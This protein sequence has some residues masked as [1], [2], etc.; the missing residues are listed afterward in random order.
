MKL[1][2]RCLLSLWCGL[3]AF[4]V[5]LAGCLSLCLLIT[6]FFQIFNFMFGTNANFLRIHVPYF[7]IPIQSQIELCE[8]LGV[9]TLM[10]FCL[11]F[12]I[13]VSMKLYNRTK[14]YSKRSNELSL[15]DIP[16]QFPYVLYLRSFDTQE[17]TEKIIKNTPQTEEEVLVNSLSPIGK[18]VAIGCPSDKIPPLGGYR[19]YVSDDDWQNTV[20]QL[21]KDAKLTALRIGETE[22]LGW[23]IK[24]TLNN[25]SDLQKL[26]FLVPDIEKI[27]LSF[28]AKLEKTIQE[29]PLKDVQISPCFFN[30][31]GWGSVSSIIYF[32]K[33]ENDSGSVP[34]YI[35]KQSMIPRQTIW[36]RFGNLSSAFQKAMFPVYKQFGKLNFKIRFFNVLNT[37]IFYILIPIIIICSLLLN[38]KLTAKKEI[39][40]NL[41]TQAIQQAEQIYPEL[42]INLGIIERDHKNISIFTYGHLGCIHLSDEQLNDFIALDIQVSEKMRF[43]YSMINKAVAQLPEE[44]AIKYNNLLLNSVLNGLGYKNTENTPIDTPEEFQK[45]LLKIKSSL[46]EEQYETIN[47]WITQMAEK[48]RRIFYPDQFYIDYMK[49]INDIPD[50]SIKAF[51]FR[52]YFIMNFSR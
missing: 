46:T 14:L 8:M 5:G 40:A 3:W 35:M 25:I 1:E 22:G 18:T 16:L 44:D 48:P 12:C 34:T 39:T 52:G 37:Y 28:F 30:K 26:I 9:Y 32:E 31:Q 42:S 41:F 20:I 47:K 29:R 6:L 50:A 19:I 10:T 7:Y 21:S 15:S 4:I 36:N 51:L 33:Q 23:E 49:F 45:K 38:M 2:K 13:P 24:Y 11:L 27:N 43:D 17:I